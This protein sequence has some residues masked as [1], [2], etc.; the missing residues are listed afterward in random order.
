MAIA[1]ANQVL[2]LPT[3]SATITPPNRSIAAIAR[4]QAGRCAGYRQLGGSAAL[5]CG[6]QAWPHCHRS[7]SPEAKSAGGRRPPTGCGITRSDSATSRDERIDRLAFDAS[8]TQVLRREFVQLCGDCVA[9]TT[10]CYARQ[11]G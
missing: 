2:P 11:F 5:V 3:G 6:C 8:E 10:T 4:R 7:S 1:I 9:P